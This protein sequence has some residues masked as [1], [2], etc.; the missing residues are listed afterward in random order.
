[1]K[2]VVSKVYQ[3][4]AKANRGNAESAIERFLLR[5]FNSADIASVT[6]QPKSVGN[7]LRKVPGVV[8]EFSLNNKYRVYSKCIEIEPGVVAFC[9]A[10]VG[11]KGVT[12]QNE[13]I[14]KALAMF[15]D[16]KA[17]EWENWEPSP[18]QIQAFFEQ[19]SQII[20]DTPQVASASAQPEQKTAG[21]KKKGKPVDENGL[22][23]AERKA[24]R[25][26]EQQEEARK[27][28]QEREAAEQKRCA[29]VAAEQAK[30]EKT[31]SD[32]AQPEKTDKATPDEQNVVSEI[33]GQKD[34]EDKPAVLLNGEPAPGPQQIT[35][36]VIFQDIGRVR[37]QLELID[38]QIKI[39]KLQMEIVRQ[40]IAMA[41]HEIALEELAIKKLNLLQMQKAKGIQK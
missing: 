6:P 17:T 15:D 39:Q 9:L 3:K 32:I 7:N 8:D 4:W 36:E 34:K 19:D 14:L 31:V 5:V 18:D 29:A 28:K 16:V 35:D 11:A 23:C 41:Q 30:Q 12:N 2:I 22:T 33:L 13:D 40:K 20:D 27:R 24:L 38:H 21:K 25:K 1:M 10:T 37:Y 26:K